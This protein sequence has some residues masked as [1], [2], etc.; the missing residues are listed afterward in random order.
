MACVMG[1]GVYSAFWLLSPVAYASR[2]VGALQ[3]YRY[4]QHIPCPCKPTHTYMGQGY[5]APTALR[6]CTREFNICTLAI[7][8]T[9]ITKYA[10][11]HVFGLGYSCRVRLVSPIVVAPWAGRAL[12]V[13][14]NGMLC[15]IEHSSLLA[16]TP[17]M[18]HQAARTILEQNHIITMYYFGPIGIAKHFGYVR[19]VVPF[20]EHKVG[21][22]ILR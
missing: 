5:A 2:Y 3:T 22:T 9:L 20:D 7:C 12:C 14:D 15:A 4:M 18:A 10:L 8:Y 6:Q 16:R 17:R 1:S 13:A 11:A 19:G 21:S